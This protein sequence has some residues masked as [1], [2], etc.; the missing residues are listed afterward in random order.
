MQRN[1]F[2]KWS[3]NLLQP[4][5]GLPPSYDEM[6]EEKGKVKRKR[7]YQ[8]ISLKCSFLSFNFMSGFVKMLAMLSSMAT[9]RMVRFPFFI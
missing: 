3:H 2:T 9:F 1:F 7:I 8:P 6:G 4:R 5:L